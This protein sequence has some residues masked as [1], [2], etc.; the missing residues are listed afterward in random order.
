MR[1]RFGITQAVGVQALE[2]LVGA[3]ILEIKGT[4]KGSMNVGGTTSL[5]VERTDGQSIIVQSE[6]VPDWLNG[7]EVP[8]RLL[9]RAERATELSEVRA[10]LIAVASEAEMATIDAAAA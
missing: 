7:N 1:K 4:V 6:N 2:T 8:A 3:R 10:K 5:L 9:V